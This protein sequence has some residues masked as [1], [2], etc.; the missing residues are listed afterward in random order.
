M[1][2]AHEVRAA[3]MAKTAAIKSKQNAKYAVSIYR[4]AKSG[5]PDPELNQALKKEIEK[6]KKEQIPADVIKR[7]I[8]KAKGGSGDSYEEIRYE[9][10]GPNNSLIM[11]DCVTDNVNRT[12]TAVRT[13][14]S[15]TGCKL[16][17]SGSVSHM[18]TNQALFSFEGMTE[19]EVLELLVM[20]D[21]DVTDLQYED[22]LISI[23][24]PSTE[25]SKIRDA[26]TE[27]K[28]ELEFLEDEVTWVPSMYVKLEDPDDI[29]H[30]KRLKEALDENDDVQ[31]I[32]HNIE[33]LPESEEE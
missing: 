23:Y 13:I 12:Y 24:A 31:Q 30:F 32:Y 28:P 3:S 8:E 5:V 2:R 1:G 15:R 19:E 9:G 33:D 16:G 26:L 25:Y 11:V 18:F 7:A 14:F 29:K 10:F 20:A 27:N 6:A 17:V 22:G 21:C 4:A